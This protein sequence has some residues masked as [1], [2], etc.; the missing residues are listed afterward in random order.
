MQSC[1][2]ARKVDDIQKLNHNTIQHDGDDNAQSTMTLTLDQ[3][4]LDGIP[5]LGDGVQAVT[6]CR[7]SRMNVGTKT[8][9]QFYTRPQLAEKYVAT[10]IERWCDPDVLFVAPAAGAGALRQQINSPI[11]KLS[12]IIGSL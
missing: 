12:G 1:Q 6:S 10:V 2:Q 5:R 9:D 3:M 8:L 4:E 7:P 11:L